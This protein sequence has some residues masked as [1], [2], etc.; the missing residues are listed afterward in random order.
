MSRNSDS[1]RGGWDP[2]TPKELAKLAK[3][4]RRAHA[5]IALEYLEKVRKTGRHPEAECCESLGAFRVRG[6]PEDEWQEFYMPMFPP[7]R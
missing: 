2:I 3:S 5:G 7:G 4:A 1:Q 6:G